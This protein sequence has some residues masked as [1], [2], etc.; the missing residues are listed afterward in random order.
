MI[1]EL[2]IGRY[3]YDHGVN[4]VRLFLHI[5][6]FSDCIPA[7]ISGHIFQVEFMILPASYMTTD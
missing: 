6:R 2:L 5:Y 4:S 1:L 7:Y 3:K